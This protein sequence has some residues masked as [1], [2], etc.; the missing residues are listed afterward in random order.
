M[1]DHKPESVSSSSLIKVGGSNFFNMS[2]AS[3]ID[4][5]KAAAPPFHDAISRAL[6]ASGTARVP[7]PVVAAAERIVKSET[8]RDIRGS[9]NQ[10]TK[11][12]PVRNREG[13]KL[14]IIKAS[15]GET[16]KTRTNVHKVVDKEGNTWLEKETDLTLRL[17]M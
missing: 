14:T 4:T 16:K 7:D 2:D 1:P 6:T 10:F 11:G 9:T 13:R 12:T 15:V 3:Q 5:L 8:K 17:K